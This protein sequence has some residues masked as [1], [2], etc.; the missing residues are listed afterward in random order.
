MPEPGRASR[1]AA[2]DRR[3]RGK[4]R[5]ASVFR[6]MRFGEVVAVVVAAILL[7]G[8]LHWGA[9]LYDTDGYTHLGLA[10]AYAE[11]GI[12][13]RVETARFSAMHEGFGDKEWFF[14]ALL[15]PAVLWLPPLA[16]GYAA[17]VGFNV[18]LALVLAAI[19]R[20]LLG[21]WGLLLPFVLPALSLEMAWRLVRLRPELLALS[22]MLVALVLLA[23][24]RP[25]SLMVVTFLFTWSYTAFHAL[26]GVLGLASVALLLHQRTAGQS[27]DGRLQLRLFLAPPLGA[28]AAL[29]LHPHFPH[30][31]A[32]WLIQNVQFFRAKAVLDAGTEIRPN[33]TSVMLQ[34]NLGWWLVLLLVLGALTRAGTA[35]RGAVEHDEPQDRFVRLAIVFGTAAVI[36]VALYLLMSRFSLYAFPL[37]TLALISAA[38][39]GGRRLGAR[40]TVVSVGSVPFRPLVVV[41]VLAA[42]GLGAREWTRFRDRTDLGPE[43]ARLSEWQK[44][45]D[46]LSSDTRVAADWRTTGVL[47]YWAPARYLNLL[48]PVFMAFPH[49][50]RHRVL[51]AVLAG[52]EPD[53]VAA[54]RGPL[55]SEVLAVSVARAAPRLLARL[56]SDPR[57]DVLHDGTYLLVRDAGRTG[58]PSPWLADGWT[59]VEGTRSS[60]N[61]Q[62]ASVPAATTG[63]VGGEAFEFDGDCFTVARKVVWPA[64]GAGLEFAPNGP[65]LLRW[66]GAVLASVQ[67]DGGAIHG[68]ALRLTLPESEVEPVSESDAVS[69]SVL[70]SD[71]GSAEEAPPG[72]S[73]VV[74]TCRPRDG[75]RAGFYLRVLRR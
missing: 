42:L 14:H 11:E 3:S 18:L 56:R 15:V 28:V 47:S 21:R 9:G 58:P 12:P 32:I 48:D 49:P 57:L 45:G 35:D 70:G 65:G 1:E 30:N 51:R 26:L 61:A 75:S 20:S 46:L 59:G 38:R 13:H 37:T 33:L 6:S 27:V 67:G 50:E 24:R 41:V 43:R 39:A 16:A 34:A 5:A 73:L 64:D 44:I 60:K 22:L 36:F 52:H 71:P 62:A 68:Q 66:N 55:D 40:W 2:D 23:E 8:A 69:G 17:L 4:R 10:R 31:L 54:L 74:S 19:G 72:G 29:V 53:V 25:W 7:H 63:F